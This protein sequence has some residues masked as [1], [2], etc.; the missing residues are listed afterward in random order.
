MNAQNVAGTTTMPAMT[1]SPYYSNGA[2]IGGAGST[3]TGSPGGSGL[4][5]LFIPP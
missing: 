1:T 5:V 2:A 4:V 3:S